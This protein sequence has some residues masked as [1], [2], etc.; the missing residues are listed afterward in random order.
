MKNRF[1]ADYIKKNQGFVEYKKW[2][3]KTILKH[4]IRYNGQKTNKIQLL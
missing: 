4:N 1:C 2:D 3:L